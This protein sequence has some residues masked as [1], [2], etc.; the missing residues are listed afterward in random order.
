MSTQNKAIL[1]IT[2]GTEEME[3]VI[4]IDVLRRAEIEVFVLGV[5][6]HKVPFILCS[7]NTKLVPDG[8]LD[9]DP[10]NFDSY[11]AVIIPGGAQGAKLLSENDQVQR[12][13]ADFYA[14]GKIVAAICA[15]TL[16]IKTANLHNKR[17]KKLHIT[18]HPS[19][20]DQLEHDFDFLADRVVVD[21]HLITAAGPGTTFEFAFAIVNKMLGESVVKE[22][23]RPMCFE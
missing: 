5:A 21:D 18:C 4:T 2:E 11:N 8:F 3:A 9:F 6:S 20:K 15:G 17:G 19:V 7:R 22:V 23:A 13:M 1:F 12:I 10:I 16:A 14:Q